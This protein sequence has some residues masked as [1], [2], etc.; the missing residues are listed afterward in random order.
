MEL[1]RGL[2]VS[3]SSPDEHQPQSAPNPADVNADHGGDAPAPNPDGSPLPADWHEVH[4]E[5]AYSVPHY[6]HILRKAKALG[7]ELPCVRDVAFGLPEGRWFLIRHDV[8]VSPWAAEQLAEIEAQEG[9]T[10]TY[11]YRFHANWYNL[12]DAGIVR[13]VKRVAEMGHEVGLHYEPGHFLELGEDPVA[14]IQRDIRNFEELVGFETK[15]IAQHQP[16]EGPLLGTISEQ[17]AD[18]YQ[19]D[20]VRTIRYFGDSGFHWRE[21]CI[22]TKLGE[23][24]RLHTL[25]HPHSWT[26]YGMPWQDVLRA[27]AAQL[28]GRL[29]SEMEDYIAHVSDYLARRADLD[30]EREAKYDASD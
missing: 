26:I 28:G 14:G 4:D 6:R 5:H 23:H 18:A 10:T 25:I 24:E 29:A 16:A 19:E 8:D 1:L 30:R 12:L 21:G 9:V 3:A 7:Y 27:H 2:A 15:T 11:Y 13:S 17:H 20:L 22:C